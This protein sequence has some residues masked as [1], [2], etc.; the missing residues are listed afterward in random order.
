MSLI[1]YVDAKSWIYPKLHS[2]YSIGPTLKTQN[3]SETVKVKKDKIKES[4]ILRYPKIHKNIVLGP[5]LRTKNFSEKVKVKPHILR[6]QNIHKYILH[7][8]NLKTQ[9]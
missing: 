5:T 8:P 7:C 1:I 2:K 3:F 9:N 6:Y 4:Y